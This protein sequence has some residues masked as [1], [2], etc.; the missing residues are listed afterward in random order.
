[1][2][3]LTATFFV[4]LALFQPA[5]PAAAAPNN[6]V[7]RGRAL[8]GATGSP[9]SGVVMV[10]TQTRRGAEDTQTY[11]TRTDDGGRYRFEGLATGDRLLYA[12]DAR[13]DGGLFAGRVLQIPEQD[14]PAPVIDTT[15]KVW[16]TTSDPRAVILARDDLFVRPAEGGLS[17]IESV[18][19]ANL[20]HLAYIGRASSMSDSTL[21]DRRQSASLGFA[22]PADGECRPAECGI[23]A[24]EPIDIPVIVPREY[25]FAATVAI[26]PGRSQITYSYRVEG[27]GGSFDLS[28]TA[29]YPTAE[30]SI[31]ATEPLELDSA[32]LFPDGERTI[33]DDS[34]RVWSSREGIDAGDQ[35]GAVA[36]AQ[37]GASAALV[38]GVGALLLVL[39]LAGGYALR[40]RRQNLPAP[41]RP[42]PTPRGEIVRRIAELDLAFEAGDLER[43]AW[44]IER[45][46]LKARLS[47]GSEETEPVP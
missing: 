14:E 27:S 45:T 10:L 17:V 15:L 23:V 26:P 39:L 33:G 30:T 4:A 40:R 9:Q 21:S 44:Q 3:R 41:A 47:E 46:R 18:T 20:T 8:N 38:G 2:R 1:M 24:S 6:G 34:Y 7:I 12:L 42:E 25:G 13:Y 43:E 5:S 29:L 11:K 36:V 28:R 35:I 16:K 31:Y 32:R 19:V 22:L 37:A